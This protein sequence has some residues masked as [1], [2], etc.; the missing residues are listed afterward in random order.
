M[1]DEPRRDERTRT[2]RIATRVGLVGLAIVALTFAWFYFSGD[3]ASAEDV[4]GAVGGTCVDTGWVQTDAFE[5]SETPMYDCEINGTHACVTYEGGVARDV[6]E[7]AE[8][9]F[10][11]VLSENRPSCVP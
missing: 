6:T 1:S 5:Q 4:S 2:Q 11:D 10:A 8:S 9:E 3:G 7:W